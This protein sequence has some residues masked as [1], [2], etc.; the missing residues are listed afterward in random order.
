MTSHHLEFSSV[1]N[2][3]ACPQGTKKLLRDTGENV[4]QPGYIGRRYSEGGVVIVGQNPASPPPNLV[5]LDR[6]YMG[7]LRRLA[8]EK[9]EVAYADL[10][11]NLDEFIP[12]WPFRRLFPLE[13]IGLTLD[14]V[15]F[16]N[17]VRC[18]TAGG[19]APSDAM[20]STCVDR[21]FAQWLSFLAP[22]VVVF[23]GKAPHDWVAPLLRQKQ[24]PCA[25][26]N[27][28]RHLD[29]MAREANRLEVASFVRR[30]LGR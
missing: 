7:H 21:H 25:F 4:P 30:V 2:C 24:I 27:C 5:Q 22:K 13:E 17:L 6:A 16:F 9:S 1:I 18:R 20:F 14:E 8:K 28:A 10:L 26:I 23:I 15:A 19:G 11:E 12:F 29:A 3:T